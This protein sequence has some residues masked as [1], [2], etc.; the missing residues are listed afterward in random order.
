MILVPVGFGL[1][2]LPG[3]STWV[4]QDLC[5]L[6]VA[7]ITAEHLS[8]TSVGVFHGRLDRA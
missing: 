5:E 1:V 8:F 3:V 2:A 4:V 7:E 6:A